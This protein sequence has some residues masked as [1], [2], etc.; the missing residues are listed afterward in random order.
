MTVSG[1]SKIELFCIYMEL[2]IYMKHIF[3]IT[4]IIMNIS[5]ASDP[6][7]AYDEYIKMLP[8][9]T[10]LVYKQGYTDGC[11]SGWNAAGNFMTTFKRSDAYLS[12]DLYTRAWDKGY[13]Y[14]KEQFERD[15]EFERIM[16]SH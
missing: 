5:C 8:E 15:R 14:C 7:S 1:H 4:L 3:S 13:E 10:P 12:D 6:Y 16:L 9:N 2:I 11:D